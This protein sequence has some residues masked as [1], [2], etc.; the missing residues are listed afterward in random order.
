[1]AVLNQLILA[2]LLAVFVEVGAASSV[3]NCGERTCSQYEYCSD[4]ICEDCAKICTETTHNYDESTCKL[5][6]E[7]YIHDH[8]LGFVRRSEVQDLI[9]KAT[10]KQYVFSLI[11]LFLSVLIVVFIIGAILYVWIQYRRRKIVDT[12]KTMKKMQSVQVISNNN[13]AIDGVSNLNRLHLKMPTPS[14][15]NKDAPSEVT[16]TTPISTRHPTEDA[17]LEYA[18]DN[19]VLTHSPTSLKESPRVRTETSF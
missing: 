14:I 4:F 15:D 1:M 16:I 18:Y 13:S 10:S 7:D 5:N 3:K 12:S 2:G 17:T 19:P 9:D 6:C 11:S 8:V